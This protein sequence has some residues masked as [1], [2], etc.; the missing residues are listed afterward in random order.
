MW[1]DL[2]DDREIVAIITERAQ[3][4]EFISIVSQWPR[5]RQQDLP[6]CPLR[7]KEVEMNS[8]NIFY[9]CPL[10]IYY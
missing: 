9:F 8:R 5:E 1:S 10:S 7:A 4:Y 6:V 3:V 2:F